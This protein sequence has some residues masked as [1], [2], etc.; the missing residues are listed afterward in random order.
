[1]ED[2]VAPSLTGGVDEPLPLASTSPGGSSKE[3]GRLVEFLLE[4]L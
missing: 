4:E 3:E 1:M 2:A